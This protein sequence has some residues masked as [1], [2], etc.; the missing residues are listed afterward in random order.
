MNLILN[1]HAENSRPT[2]SR[3]LHKTVTNQQLTQFHRLQ[4]QIMAKRKRIPMS[5]NLSHT[6]TYNHCNHKKRLQ[7]PCHQGKSESRQIKCQR[8]QGHL[9]KGLRLFP[10]TAIDTQIISV[11]Q[12]SMNSCPQTQNLPDAKICL[13]LPRYKE[14]QTI[15]KPPRFSLQNKC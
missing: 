6:P 11:K 10:T 5:K 4:Q 7:Q 3:I 1:C 2:P 9:A 15:N 8:S 12:L 14:Y 13:H